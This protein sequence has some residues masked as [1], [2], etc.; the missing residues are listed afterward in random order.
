M[1][2]A[3]EGRVCAWWLA[4]GRACPV[5]G[6]AWGLGGAVL[7]AVVAHT[8]MVGSRLTVW[9]AFFPKRLL[10]LIRGVLALWYWFLV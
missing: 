8:S 3:L 7:V 2:S 9:P 1:F 4:V 10:T 5:R 6:S